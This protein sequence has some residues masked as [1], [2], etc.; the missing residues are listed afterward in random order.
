[1]GLHKAFRVNAIRGGG[2]GGHLV[3]LHLP[4][5]LLFKTGGRTFEVPDFAC[6]NSYKH[7]LRKLSRALYVRKE[8]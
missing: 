8:Y 6:F 1:M 7:T 4:A 3:L 5:K 2:G